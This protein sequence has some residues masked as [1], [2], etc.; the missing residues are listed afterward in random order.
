[1]Y[2]SA[3]CFCIFL[4]DINSLCF[5]QS[6]T[7]PVHSQGPDILWLL[8]CSCPR[9]KTFKETKTFS[10][11]YHTCIHICIGCVLLYKLH[12]DDQIR[13]GWCVCL[14]RVNP[15]IFISLSFRKLPL[16]QTGKLFDHTWHVS[17]VYFYLFFLSFLSVCWWRL[18]S[19]HFGQSRIKT[20]HWLEKSELKSAGQR[21]SSAHLLERTCG[22]LSNQSSWQP[23]FGEMIVS[24][25]I[26]LFN[27]PHVAP[28]PYFDHLWSTF[29]RLLLWSRKYT[30]QCQP[31]KSKSE[32]ATIKNADGLWSK[33]ESNAQQKNINNLEKQLKH[34]LENFKQYFTHF[35]KITPA[36]HP[37][38]WVHR[39]KNTDH[40]R[41]EDA[42]KPNYNKIHSRPLW[43]PLRCLETHPIHQWPTLWTFQTTG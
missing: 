35:N 5:H 6:L 18:W 34:K 30:N 42:T 36:Q 28:G 27:G 26:K 20:S 13:I 39:D 29:Y 25:R 17:V 16:F 7:S 9:T 40:T 31:Y 32:L 14:Q 22:H 24:G 4:W 37:C 10:C 12:K 38:G 3:F 21:Q 11:R 19:E 41:E 43:I 15:P 23:S 1:M 33:K 8:H 2:G